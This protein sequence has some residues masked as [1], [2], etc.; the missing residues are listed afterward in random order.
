MRAQVALAALARQ[1]GEGDFDPQGADGIIG[2]DTADAA[3]AAAAVFPP[4]VSTTAAEQ[5]ALVEAIGAPASS[6]LTAISRVA[7]GLA[8]AF[9]KW[10]V[11]ITVS[12]DPEGAGANAARNAS[13]LRSGAREA[14]ANAE[15]GAADSVYQAVPKRGGTVTQR[16]AFWNLSEQVQ[17][18]RAGADAAASVIEEVPP[19]ATDPAADDAARAATA[20]A[21]AETARLAAEETERLR[22]EQAPREDLPPVVAPSKTPWGWILG[23]LAGVATAG[24][25]YAYYR[26]RR[27]ASGMG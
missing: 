27:A 22:R 23:I 26:K 18:A 21:E 8:T 20:A 3:Q 2:S 7:D 4:N 15:R 17:A 10:V 16:G 14:A 12:G 9:E 13:A 5:T 11:A 19:E 1:T 25:G 24:G 6:R